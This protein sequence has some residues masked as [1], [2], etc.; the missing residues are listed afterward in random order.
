MFTAFETYIKEHA[1]VTNSD[2]NLMRSMAVERKL[3][4]KEFL[5]HEGETCRYESHSTGSR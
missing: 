4:R 5:L 2:I 1:N 3:G